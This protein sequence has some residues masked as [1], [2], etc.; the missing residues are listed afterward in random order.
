ME[1]KKRVEKGAD[2]FTLVGG[3]FSRQENLHRMIVLAT[4]KQISS[5]ARENLKSLQRGLDRVHS[6]SQSR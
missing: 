4:D 2:H 6:Y 1:D 5:L 3:G